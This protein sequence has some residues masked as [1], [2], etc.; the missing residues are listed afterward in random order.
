MKVLKVRIV[1]NGVRTQGENGEEDPAGAL[2]LSGGPVVGVIGKLYRE[3][4][5]KEALLA[6]AELRKSF[7]EIRLLLIG[8][9]SDPG[10]KRELEAVVSTHGLKDQVRFLGQR[11]DGRRLMGLMDVLFHSRFHLED[12][13]IRAEFNPPENK[14]GIAFYHFEYRR[15]RF[16]CQGLTGA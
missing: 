15:N 6:L 3:K 13:H 5:Q 4:G 12:L 1:R 9:V 14:R 8:G 16:V 11:R 7:P 10:F 2:G